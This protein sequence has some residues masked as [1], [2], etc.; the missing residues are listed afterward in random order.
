M[1]TM[2]GLETGKQ[3]RTIKKQRKKLKGLFTRPRV[4]QKGRSKLIGILLV[5]RQPGVMV[6]SDEDKKI[7]W[8]SYHK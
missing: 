3:V 2:K 6:A 1:E 5:S 4:K 8:K 7:V